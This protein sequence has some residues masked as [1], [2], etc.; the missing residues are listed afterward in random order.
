MLQVKNI[1]KEYITGDIKQ[2]ALK[3][4]NL[5]FR[6]SE[7]VSILGPSGS[8]KTTLLNIIGGLDSYDSGDLIIN[9]ISTKNYKDRD[10]DSY[11]NETIGF[12]FQS[13]N[14]IPHQSVLENVELA[15]TISGISSSERKKR[16]IE[17]LEKVGLGEHIKKKPNQLS[18]GQMQRVAIARALVNDPDI[19]LADEP[20]GAL[21]TDTS[22]QIME[23][24][25]EVAKERLVI[26]VT[27]N[28]E[29]ASDY[30]TRIITLKDGSVTSDTNPL[31]PKWIKPSDIKS[32][33]KAG[34]SWATSISLS[35][36][37]LSTKKR[38]TLLTAFAGSIGIIGIA[39]I[40]SLSTG[41]NAYIDDIQEETMSSYPITIS[42]E[43]ISI[44]TETM[45]SMRGTKVQESEE[46]LEDGVY[47]DTSVLETVVSL[48]ATNNLTEFKYYLENEENE[49]NEYL[50]ENGIVYSYDTAFSVY[51]YDSDG[52]LVNTDADTSELKESSS[53][54]SMAMSGTMGGMDPLS[55]MSSLSSGGS[56]SAS[57]FSELLAGND[58]AVSTV[59][60]DSYDLLAGTWPEAYDEVI[61]FVEQDQTL[62]INTLYQLGLLTEESYLDMVDAAENDEEIEVTS[63]DYDEILSHTFYM[64]TASDCYIENEDGLFEYCADDYFTE[65]EEA[66]TS[67]TSLKIVGI[68]YLNEDATESLVSTTIGYTSL[69]TD[70]VIEHTN[71]SDI[72]VAQEENEMINVLTG[73]E[74]EAASD[75]EKIEITIEY[76]SNMET[77]SKVN[78]YTYIMY[79]EA[80]NT[81]EESSTTET[82]ETITEIDE[83]MMMSEN[84]VGTQSTELD[85]EA[86]VEALEY[87]L[88]ET[89][90]EDILLEIYESYIGDYTYEGNLSDFGKVSYDAPSSISIYTDSFESK[91]AIALAIEEYNESADEENQIVYTDFV[92]MLTSSITSIIDV[93]SYVL[94]AFVSVSL[95]VSCIMI[96][97]ITH[98]SVMERTKE[99]GV[100]RALGASKRNI[101]QVFNAE[102]MIIGL[103]SGLLGIG[104]TML[105]NVPLTSVIQQLVGNDIV[106]S[107][108]AGNAVALIVLSV[109]ITMIG[110]IIPSRAAAKKD[111]VVALRT[112]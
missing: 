63:W 5:H 83:T 84:M 28:P 30:S 8:G 17:A 101:S 96:G 110:G 23:L 14:L 53:S 41:V 72:V 103:C 45:S 85:D 54:V 73:V 56:T 39:L 7:F 6:S 111:P 78:F 97:I 109:I 108:P 35:F 48:T 68:A 16:A 46:V 49:I 27:H 50:G 61:L 58:S 24:L 107:L 87:W 33:K 102:T 80:A 44:D 38:R 81:E 71:E 92:A 15:L 62:S 79:L 32:R 26:M 52:T 105:I 43:T 64:L 93:I 66:V 60:I 36:R 34:M 94:I 13:Y 3:F 55:S 86:K 67:G 82:D 74:F 88:N 69:L 11:R 76:I 31:L 29:L 4:V 104:V 99:I 40:L 89:P 22:Y 57:N 9:G 106:V 42:E 51:A 47:S 100:L 25:K 1:T 18:G 112:E 37:N 98:I 95:I 75:E 10:W 70:Y 12:V 65:N 59:V 21:D 19:L 77:D 20:T 91:D 2:S 90:D